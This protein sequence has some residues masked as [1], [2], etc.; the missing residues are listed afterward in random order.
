MRIYTLQLTVRIVWVRVSSSDHMIHC[1]YLAVNEAINLLTAL[2][3]CHL[4]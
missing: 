1:N 2:V 3:I 4:F